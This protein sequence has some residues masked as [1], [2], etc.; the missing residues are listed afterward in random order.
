MLNGFAKDALRIVSGKGEVD[1]I[2][3]DIIE[4]TC[5]VISDGEDCRF[6]HKSV[7][8]YHAALFIQGQPD[9]M[10]TAFYS[11]ME[12]RWSAWQQELM[13][14]ALIDRYR[15]LKLFQIKEI[16]KMLDTGGDLLRDGVPI[17]LISKICGKD[18]LTFGDDSTGGGISSLTLSSTGSFWPTWML[19]SNSEY[20]V[21][22]FAVVKNRASCEGAL[23]KSAEGDLI[24]IDQ[25][26]KIES[27]KKGVEAACSMLCQL[28]QKELREAEDFVTHVEST[29]SVFQF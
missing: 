14:L 13:F 10:A 28:L 8:E 20:A 1:R 6:I 25:L 3:S 5:L 4:I 11:A 9:E 17:E 16:C 26:M 27:L 7:Q 29:K 2:L 18:Y 15:Y 24:T 23:F 22:I 19:L 21:D 12:A